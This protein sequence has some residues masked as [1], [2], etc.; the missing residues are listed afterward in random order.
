MK[1]SL[2]VWSLLSLVALPTFAAPLDDAPEN[3]LV[4]RDADA[5]SSSTTF[6][7]IEVPPQKLLTPENFQDTIKD[8]YW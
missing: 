4:K 1:P 8:G 6:N 2:L 7:N 5:E 3:T